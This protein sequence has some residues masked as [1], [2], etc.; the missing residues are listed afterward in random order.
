M[1]TR[2]FYSKQYLNSAN[3]NCLRLQLP[4]SNKDCPRCHESEAVFFQ[5]Q[6]RTSET[7]MVNFHPYYHPTFLICCV[8][9]YFMFAAVVEKYSISKLLAGWYWCLP[10][11]PV[12][13]ILSKTRGP[14]D[15]THVV[16]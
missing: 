2:F 13:D 7:G 11:F 5:S 16:E 12:F 10:G 4:R 9:N 8:R 15:D 3:A 6:Q 14:R 1:T